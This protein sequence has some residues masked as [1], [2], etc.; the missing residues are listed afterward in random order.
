MLDQLLLLVHTTD[1]NKNKNLLLKSE[2]SLYSA[3]ENGNIGVPYFQLL[4]N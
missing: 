1:K 2:I 4:V 3:A